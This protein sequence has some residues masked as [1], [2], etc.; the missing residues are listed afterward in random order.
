MVPQG[1]PSPLIAQAVNRAA[2]AGHQG[3]NGHK[4]LVQRLS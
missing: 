3:D 2:G 1:E 4:E